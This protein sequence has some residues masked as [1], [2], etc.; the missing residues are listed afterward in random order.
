LRIRSFRRAAARVRRRSARRTAY[1]TAV[2]TLAAYS[3]FGADSVALPAKSPVRGGS[4]PTESQLIVRRFDIPAGPLTAALDAFRAVTGVRITVAQLPDAT[5]ANFQSPGASGFLTNEQALRELL[6]GTALAYRFVSPNAANVFIGGDETIDVTAHAPSTLAASLPRYNAPLREIPQSISVLP[7]AVTEQQGTTTLRDALRNVA[8]ISI[9]AGEGGAQGDNLTIRGFSARNDLFIDGMRDFGS[10][11]RDPF[12]LEELEVL[13]GPSSVTF[14]RGSTGGVVNQATKSATLDSFLDS[15]LTVGTDDTRRVTADI[16]EPLAALGDG[17]AFRLNLM[18]HDSRVAG[19]SEAQN[20][21]FGI[22]PSLTTLIG[23]SRLT[24]NYLYQS[25]NDTPDYGVPWYFDAPAPV[26]RENYY[27]FPDANFLRTNVDMATAKLERDLGATTSLRTQLRI[28]SYGRRVQITEAKLAAGV[29][30]ST[31]LDRAMV[32]RDQIAVDSD[33]AFGQLQ[34]DLTATFDT[35]GVLHSVVGGIE[36]GRE[37]SD[38]TRLAFTGVPVTSLLDPDPHQP[39][40]GTAAVSTKIRTTATT[41]GIY[42]LDT[43]HVGR[44]WDLTAGAR[45]DRFDANVDNLAGAPSTFRRVDAMPSWR[46]GVVFK[47]SGNGSIYANYSTSFNPSAEALSLSASTADTAPEEN[48][49]TELGTKWDLRN[50]R[51]SFRGALFRTEKRNARETDPTN[52]LLQILSGRQR[53]DGVELETSG[54][55]T[56]RWE[57]LAG[58]SHMNSELV[59]S[60]GFPAAVGARLAN[61]PDDTFTFWSTFHGASRFEIGAGGQYV[62][63]RTASTTAPL[64]PTTA[65]LK[66]APAYWV[67][68]A[69]I[70]HPLGD[71]IGL[72]LNLYN[73]TDA[74][75]FDQLHPGHIVPGPGRSASLAIDFQL[76]GRN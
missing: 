8:G 22:A 69:M 1:W 66:E 76:R 13:K 40:A 73:L 5:L 11:Y 9:A 4:A 37:T 58:Y 55:V 19:R 21:R 26:D 30:P 25:A 72:R 74:Y 46:G 57:L 43:L 12:A 28:A 48:R 35:G 63:S 20:R 29:T 31:P 41:L 23:E 56:E 61:V 54:H 45:W 60:V 36:A 62:G 65:Q 42:A 67:F 2:G 53:V 39:F 14:G 70:S 75:Y 51:L 59:K 64:D 44:Q 50:G 68:N 34:S 32:T 17:T 18:A 16:N 7:R 49:N 6:A 33:E 10:Y 47:P 52:A 24:L 71:R 3:A 15:T 27:G 38:P